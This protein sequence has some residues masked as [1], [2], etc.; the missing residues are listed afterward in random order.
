MGLRTQLKNI[1]KK[2]I[3]RGNNT[4]AAP[5]P[6]TP[7]VPK[8]DPIVAPTQPEPIE[9]TEK[10]EVQNDTTST[11]STPKEQEEILQEK[12]TETP[13]IQEEDDSES[14]EDSSS[15]SSEEENKEQPQSEQEG[16]DT[17]GAFAVSDIKHLFGETCP[18]CGASTFNN[19]AYADNAFVCQSCDATL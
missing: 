1:I 3:G 19:W 17:E 4:P 18:E 5:P 16:I 8:P 14:S 10:Q 12:N 9:T 7:P 2:A 6:Y 13:D 15:S 11:V